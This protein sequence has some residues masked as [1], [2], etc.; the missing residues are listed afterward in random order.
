MEQD[1]AIE[2][3]IEDIN[4]IKESGQNEI[5]VEAL[6]TYLNSI[7]GSVAESFEVEM[8]K[9]KHENQLHLNVQQHNLNT[10]LEHF[11]TVITIGANTVKILLLMNGGAAVA[12][13]AFLGNIWLYDKSARPIVPI[14]ISFSMF[15]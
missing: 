1:K 2:L 14:A 8:E 11:R 9:L 12:L 7:K 13:L 4:K 6:I 10:Y 5:Q 15:G 3:I